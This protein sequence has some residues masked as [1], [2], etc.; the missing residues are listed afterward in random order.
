M[1]HRVAVGHSVVVA[2]HSGAHELVGLA[3]SVGVHNGV[4]GAWG[5]QASRMDDCVVGELRPIPTTVPVHRVVA[6]AHRPDPSRVAQPAL[7]LPEV[8]GP[9]RGQRIAAVGEGVHDEVGHALASD[10]LNARLDV[11]PARVDTAVGDQ[12]HQVQAPA[13]TGAGRLAGALQHGVL[14]EA[15]VGN[16]FVD[17]GQVLRDDRTRTEVEVPN[18][19]VP[20]LAVGEADVAPAGRQRG[21]RVAIPQAVENQRRSLADRVARAGW[22]EAPTIEHDQRQRRDG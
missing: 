1:Q 19:G 9:R 13:G 3:T 2:D 5:L 7:E 14:E 22:R 17:P 20:H 15:A 10:Q 4:R 12:A 11:L 6:A 21:V 16:R 8:P 18:L